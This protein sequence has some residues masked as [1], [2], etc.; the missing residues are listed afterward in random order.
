MCTTTL[1]RA[2]PSAEEKTPAPPG[3]SRRPDRDE[4]I[5]DVLARL[6]RA[7][8]HWHGGSALETQAGTA[9]P[10]LVGLCG[11]ESLE[12]PREIFLGRV[13]CDAWGVARGGVVSRRCEQEE[14]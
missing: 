12:F 14:E 13:E 9:A 11:T 1:G 7:H 2:S 4:W 6:G 3:H 8:W 5:H 10:T